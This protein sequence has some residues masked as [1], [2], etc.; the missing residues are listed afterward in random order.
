MIQ[1]G[2]FPR[3]RWVVLAVLCIVTAGSAMVMISPAPLI[4][5][6][7]QATGLSLGEVAGI[8]MGTFN[9]FM[10]ISALIGGFLID[11]FGVIRVW[12]VAIVLLFLGAVLVPYV[13]ESVFGMTVIR[14]MVGCGTGPIMASAVSIAAQWFPMSERG[15]VTGVQGFSVSLGIAL[16][17]VVVPGTLQSTGSWQ[18]ALAWM[19]V[20][21]VVAFIFTLVIVFGP[22]APTTFQAMSAM[23]DSKAGSS[24][25]F[26]RSLLMAATWAGIACAFLNSWEFQAFNDLTPSY[27]AVEPP[28]G[29]GFG[30]MGAGKFMLL[31]QIAYMIGSI[32][33]GII[34]E[35]VF[36]GRAKPMVMIGALVSALC[37]FA[38]K[39]SGVY[40]NDSVLLLALIIFGFFASIVNPQVN[41]FI[42]KNYPEHITGKVAGLTMALCGFGATIGVAAGAFALHA[43]GLYQMSI[44][45]VVLVGIIGCVVGVALNPPKAFRSKE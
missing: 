17:F 28:V 13:G 8:T 7:A 12:L 9:L 3:F 39:F 22:K 31:A 18:A 34:G 45:I 15:I 44:N 42:A 43:T 11:R 10:A 21:M 37:C 25:D 5:V 36:G 30:P 14:A 40:T 16:G 6:I 4:G 24:A 33:S 29:I 1:S 19:S 20:T 27:L 26:K 35:K 32:L 23:A 38:L 41:A 2:V